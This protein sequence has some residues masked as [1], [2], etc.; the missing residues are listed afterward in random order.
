MFCEQCEQTASGNGCH[1]WGACGKSPQVNAVQDLLVYCL[2][3]TAPVV[4]EAKKLG[5][6][7]REVDRFTCESLFATMTNVNFDQKRFTKYIKKA[8]ALRENLKSQIQQATQTPITWSEISTYE[9]DYNESLVEQGQ[10]YNLELIGKS[11]ANVDIF[12]LKLTALYGI[13]GAASYTF[14]AYEMGQEDELVYQFIQQVLATIDHQ[15]LATPLSQDLSLEDWVNLALEIGNINLRAMELIDA[16]HTKTYGHPV[17]TPIPL[18]VIPGKA[19]LVSGHDIK[20]LEAILKQTVDT[21]INVYTHGE[22]LPAHGYPKLKEQYSHFYGHFGT[23]WQNQTKD[24]G[25]FPGAIVVTTNCL[26]PPHEHYD[27]KL[28]T[29]GPVGYAGLNYLPAEAD[30][31]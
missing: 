6:N 1:Q 20:Q 3:G 2:R 16:G 8:I 7:T 21:G 27:E 9:P 23:A 24:F 25:K 10:N 13:K 30:G 22:L 5:M 11:G 17:P 15:H 19:I 12:S 4:L 18:N 31:R 26:M 14:H 28:F 29:L